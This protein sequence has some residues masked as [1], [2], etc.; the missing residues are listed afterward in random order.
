[1]S[2]VIIFSNPQIYCNNLTAYAYPFFDGCSTYL[3]KKYQVNHE[4]CIDHELPV[5]DVLLREVPWGGVDL[6]L[7]AVKLTN[8]M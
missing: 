5:P 7:N 1:M 3:A 2:Q 4:P 6:P 8:C